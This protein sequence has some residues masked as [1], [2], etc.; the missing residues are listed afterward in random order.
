MK[1][2]VVWVKKLIVA[3]VLVGFL[4]QIDSVY[5]MDCTYHESADHQEL[6]EEDIRAANKKLLHASMSGNA[7]LVIEAIGEGARVN[8][9]NRY[10]ESPLAWAASRGHVAV[11]IILLVSKAD[12]HKSDEWGATSLDMAAYSGHARIV[13]TLLTGRADPNHGDGV[14]TT[15]TTLRTAVNRGHADIVKI[16]VAAQA[17]LSDTKV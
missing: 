14:G 10:R 11:V 12:V 9:R 3:V 1:D 5:A 8:R 16:L 13:E 6:T 7:P 4:G 17:Q 15:N 2:S